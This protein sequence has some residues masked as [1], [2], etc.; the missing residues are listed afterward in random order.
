LRI[1]CYL[2]MSLLTAAAFAATPPGVVI[3]HSP[4]SSRCYIGSPSLAILSSGDYVASH[5]LF[6]PGSGNRRTLV[7]RSQDKGLTWRKQAELDGQWWSTLFTNGGALYILGTTTEYGNAVIRRSLD[8]GRTW[9][10]PTNRATGL[11][12]EDGQYHCAPMPV[13]THRGRLWRAMERRD[14]P[15]GWGINFRAGMMSAPMDS[16][17]LQA[18]NWRCSQFV[19]SDTNW[20]GG[21]FGGWL[22]G[23]AVVTRGGNLLDVL[24]VDTVGYPEKAALVNI[25]SDGTTASFD[26]R[27]GFVD[28]PGGAKKFTI[29]YDPPSDRYWS[30]ATIVPEAVQGRAP[31]RKPGGV[32][33]TLALTCS[34]DLTNWVVRAPLLQHPDIAAH[35]FQ[36]VDWLFEGPDL[37]AVCRTAFDDEAGGAHN[38]HDANFLT[39]HRVSNFRSLTAADVRRP[40]NEAELREWLENMV[41]FHRFTA[42]EVSAATGLA[43]TEITA[44]LERFGLAG[45]RPPARAAGA[46]LR[47]LPYPGGRHPRI[48]FLE[49]AVRPQRETKVSVFTPWDDAGYVVVDVPE[50]IFSQLGLIYLAHTH[51]PTVWDQKGIVLPQLEWDRRADG[52]LESARTLPNGIAFG[53]RIIPTPTAVRMALWLRNGTREKLTGLRVQ[54]CVMLKAAAGFAAQTL[55]NK[56]FKAPYAAARSEDGRR[57]VVTAWDPCD[58]CW[59]NDQV[60]C[61]HADPKFPDCAPGQTQRLRGW[62][63]FYEGTDI[64][65]ELQRIEQTG[66]RKPPTLPR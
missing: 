62:L 14:P 13:I 41:V 28:F 37:I 63:S 61:L 15:K 5:D 29:R 53:A 24:R 16:D 34:A 38:N 64:E 6:G 30:L 35:G 54:N 48:G 23:N 22:E 33:N 19:P 55:T 2:L 45:R 42:E 57:W 12:R 36:Y 32:R 18:T 49:G 8:G 40:A 50:A 26:A 47:V 21:T 44:A 31:G 27:A 52:T 46:P 10:S 51:I 3:D 11:Q 4:A 60:P 43:A 66:W 39:F 1:F 59:G 7:F 58:R 65:A 56:L 9:T 25:N 17:L 20:L